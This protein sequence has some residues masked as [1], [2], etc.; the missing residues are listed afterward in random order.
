MKTNRN[1]LLRVRYKILRDAGYSS[2]EANKMKYRN[3]IGLKEDLL[4]RNG[5][6]KKSGYNKALKNISQ[7][8]TIDNWFKNVNKVTKENNPST[9]SEW[10]YITNRHPYKTQTARSAKVLQRKHNFS[11]KQSYY[12]LY[13][14]YEGKKGYKE[15]LNTLAIDPLFEI[16]RR[17]L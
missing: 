11:N 4:F 2:Y 16:Y 5:K 6:V 1:L 10:G 15:I 12:F 7:V 3:E 17:D 8:T 9:L 13:L 14:M